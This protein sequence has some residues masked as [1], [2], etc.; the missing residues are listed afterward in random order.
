MAMKKKPIL[1]KTSPVILRERAPLRIDLGSG[2]R[3]KEGFDGVDVVPNVAKYCADLCSGDPWPF[4]DDS[5]DEM[6]SSHYIEHIDS[7]SIWNFQTTKLPDGSFQ[8]R[9]VRGPNAFLWFFSEAFRV[10]KN[11]CVFTIQWPACQSVRAYQDPTHSHFIPA[12][13]MI[14]LSAEGRASMGLQHYEATCNW[15][16]TVQPLINVEP[17]TDEDKAMALRA[18]SSDEK[19][20]WVRRKNDEQI[21]RYRGDWNYVNDFIAVLKA[22]K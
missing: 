6:C 16:G 20:A 10:A 17:E 9:R 7:G 19:Q 12:E 22:I 4:A 11:G 13:R 8:T 15:M 1:R 5:V 21:R 14:Y 3:P 2:P 18:D